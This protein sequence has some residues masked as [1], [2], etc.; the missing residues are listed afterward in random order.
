VF[1]TGERYA[2]LIRLTRIVDHLGPGLARAL[3]EHAT[4]ADERLDIG[5]VRCRIDQ[6]AE[7]AR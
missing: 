6:G 3:Q 5:V 7:T 4:H 1:G 2:I